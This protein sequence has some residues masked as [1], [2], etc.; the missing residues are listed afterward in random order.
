MKFNRF[1][2]SI[3][4]FTIGGDSLMKNVIIDKFQN[5][6]AIL[7]MKIKAFVSQNIQTETALYNSGLNKP[8]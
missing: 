7:T 2:Y 6:N 8:R 4:E 5:E 3:L 1:Y